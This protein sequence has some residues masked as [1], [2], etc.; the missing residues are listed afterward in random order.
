MALDLE[1]FRAIRQT[2][3]T[4]QRFFQDLY[5]L[6]RYFQKAR[7]SVYLCAELSCFPNVDLR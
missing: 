5:V 3:G 7:N 1:Q 6:L 2:L 4:R